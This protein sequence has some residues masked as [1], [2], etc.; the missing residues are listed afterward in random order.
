MWAELDTY[1]NTYTLIYSKNMADR[2]PSLPEPPLF[3][4]ILF[5]P[6]TQHKRVSTQ[7]AAAVCFFFNPPS[8]FKTT[9]SSSFFGLHA[10]GGSVLEHTRLSF[11]LIVYPVRS[12]VCLRFGRFSFVISSP[13]F[14]CLFSMLLLLFESIRVSSWFF[15]SILR[16]VLLFVVSF[17]SGLDTFLRFS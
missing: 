17:S 4:F 2:D 3:Y 9:F 11:R 13:F 8:Y 15:S 6:S 14:L 5:S 16:A 10:P 1:T 12:C 7:Q